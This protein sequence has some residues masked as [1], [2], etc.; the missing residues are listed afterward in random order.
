MNEMFHIPNVSAT[1]GLSFNQKEN[2][3]LE[4]MHVFKKN[5]WQNKS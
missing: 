1:D 5:N 2:K 4:G 3:M